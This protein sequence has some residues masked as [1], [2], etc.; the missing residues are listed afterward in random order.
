MSNAVKLGVYVV[1]IALAV[2]FGSQ[3][4]SA[5]TTITEANMVKGGMT[6]IDPVKLHKLKIGLRRKRAVGVTNGVDEVSGPA[7]TATTNA[8]PAAG[9]TNVV[10][11]TTNEPAGTNT[12]RIPAPLP[13]LDDMEIDAPPSST[14]VAYLGLFVLSMVVL[15]LLVANDFSHFMAQRAVGFVFND[16]GVGQRDPEYE[17]AEHLWASGDH[18][19]AISRMRSYLRK[20]PREQY[21]ALRIAEIYEKDLRNYL[22]AALEYEEILKHKIEPERWGWAAIHLCNLYLKMGQTTKTVALLR[23]ID[24]EYG[25]TAAAEKARKRLALFDASGTE[26]LQ[27]D[28]QPS[29]PGS[30]EA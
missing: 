6:Q 27:T 7:P 23:R 20:H 21:V 12:A 5:F 29:E 4:Y 11:S 26:A 16:D 18:M 14:M 17:D 15:G 10:S 30:P 3:F 2:W 8:P 9:A 24:A 25:E 22:A 19:E 1:F 13:N 28:E